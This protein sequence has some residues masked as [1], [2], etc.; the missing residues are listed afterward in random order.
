MMK[1]LLASSLVAVTAVFWFGPQLTQMTYEPAPPAEG[2]QVP[3][4]EVT[5]LDSETAVPI[6]DIRPVVTH[7]P[8][9][10]AVRAIYMTACVAGT[11]SFRD[12]LVKLIEETEINSLVL[13]IKDYSGTISFPSQSPAWQPAWQAAECGARDMREFIADLHARGIFVIGRI[14]VFQDPFYAVRH[15]HL[16][17]LRADGVTVWRDHKGLSFIDVAAREYWDHIVALAVESYNLGFD[18]LNFDY[19]RYPSDGNMIDIS[20]PHTMASE[21]GNDRPANLEAFFAYLHDV[22]SDEIQFAEYR[23]ANTGRDVAIPWLSADLFGMTTT[24]YDDLSIGQI[25][26]RAAPYFDVIAPMVYPS[27]YPPNYLGLGD[28]NDHP[29]QIVFHA[30][31]AGVVRMQASTTRL[32]GFRHERL[33]TTTPPVYQKPVYGPER[34]RTWIQ[35]FN[36]GGVYDATKVRAQIQASYDAGVESWMIW[37]PS[38]RYTRGALLPATPPA[39]APVNSTERDRDS[40]VQ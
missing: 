16:A 10:E 39:A 28:P 1:Y 11:P 37:S 31:S 27:H 7:V 21:W 30:M 26:E 24:N 12:G 5:S 34:L 18:E 33:G 32:A 19:V 8:M 22:L 25:Q 4:T 36:Y 3:F 20:F 29:Y 40:R 9:P 38:N 14:T 23:H 6:V 2:N 35:D 17:V 13:D 15:P